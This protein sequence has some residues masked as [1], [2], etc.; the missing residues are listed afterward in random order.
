MT[1]KSPDP[2]WER[3]IIMFFNICTVNRYIK[4]KLCN[5]TA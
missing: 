3:V 4:S 5:K 2:K 1:E